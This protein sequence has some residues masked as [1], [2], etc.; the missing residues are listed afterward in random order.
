MSEVFTNPSMLPLDA[1]KE[2]GVEHASTEEIDE[3]TEDY[4]N[5]PDTEIMKVVLHYSLLN[6]F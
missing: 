1:I 4:A 2:T 6:P 5:I 3:F